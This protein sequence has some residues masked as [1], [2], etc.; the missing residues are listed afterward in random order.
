M[1]TQDLSGWLDFLVVDLSWDDDVEVEVEGDWDEV[2][3]EEV[4]NGS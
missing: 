1:G 3:V 4:G 2:V